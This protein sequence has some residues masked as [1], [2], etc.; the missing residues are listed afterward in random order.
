QLTRAYFFQHTCGSVFALIPSLIKMGVDS[1]S[2]IQPL[3]RDMEAAKLKQ[4]YGEQLVFWGGI[5]TQ[6]L[7]T[8][9]SEEDVKKN[10]LK[11][12]AD[13][14]HTGYVLAPAHTL[15]QDVPAKNVIAMYR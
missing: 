13:M 3:A 15:Q 1:L 7:L 14:K 2:P 9:G 8:Q 12:L 11:V 6:Q 4:A 5:D 10:V